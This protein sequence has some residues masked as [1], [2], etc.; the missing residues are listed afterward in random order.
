MMI[1]KRK[2]E[3]LLRKNKITANIM[4]RWN[5]ET[6]PHCKFL[7]GDEVVAKTKNANWESAKNR[8]LHGL[9]GRIVA[10]TTVDGER[11]CNENRKHSAYYVYDGEQV[12]RFR[13]N[14]LVAA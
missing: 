3:S 10:V 11:I 12:V 4:M 9:S 8:R 13:S 2:T 6:N 14:S 5:R 1:P 7:P